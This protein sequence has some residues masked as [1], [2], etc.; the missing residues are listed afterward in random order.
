MG[1]TPWGTYE[2]IA[3]SLRARL[4]DAEPGGRVPSEAALAA[5]FGVARNTV[6]RA[7][8]ALEDDGVIVAL[9]GRGRVMGTA[10]AAAGYRRVADAL[11]S[12]ITSG[13]WAPGDRVPSELALM[14]QHGVSRS[15]VRRGLSVMEAEGLV[16]A[17]HGK[18][19][20]VHGSGRQ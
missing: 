16:T 4:A 18:G 14:S 17:V 2:R 9:P 10:P 1:A 7:L 12:E 15:T 11:R 13:R 3:G 8:A 6:R 5:E 19:R 20:F